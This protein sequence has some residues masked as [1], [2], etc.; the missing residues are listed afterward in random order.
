ML[1]MLKKKKEEVEL[2][3]MKAVELLPLK[4]VVVQLLKVVVLLPREVVLL[5][6][7]EVVLPL[8][9][10][11]VVLPV[12]QQLLQLLLEQEAVPQPCLQPAVAAD[13]VI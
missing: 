10:K 8:P 6:P 2:P 12:F 7:K 13:L 3:L 5:L 4:E 9:K 11:A 1:P